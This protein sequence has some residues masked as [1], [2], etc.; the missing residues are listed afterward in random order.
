MSDSEDRAE[1]ADGVEG[2]SLLEHES[3]FTEADYIR[4]KNWPICRPIL[5]HN[6]ARDVDDLALRS[7]VRLA[8]A[9]W[10]VL[11]V[12]FIGNA[13]AVAAAFFSITASHWS[14]WIGLILSILYFCVC[15]PLAFVIYFLAYEG[16]RLRS[17][18]KMGSF[19]CLYPVQI[20]LCIWFALGIPKTG[21]GG[22][23]LIVHAWEDNELGTGVLNIISLVLWLVIGFGSAYVLTA[24]WRAFKQARLGGGQKVQTAATSIEHDDARDSFLD[25]D[26]EL[27]AAV[28]GKEV[29][30]SSSTT[31]TFASWG[32]PSKI[33][34]SLNLPKREAPE[35][36]AGTPAPV[37]T[38]SYDL[39]SNFLD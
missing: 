25:V 35:K 31:S 36:V 12:A 8:Y 20:I 21:G 11:L 14:N 39:P 9:L 17:A 13:L 24:M 19:F 22:L 5:Y 37:P 26:E 7:V 34:L 3:E 29:P 2:E 33:N 6:I 32:L 10:Y 16:A 23:V 27:A 4:K 1:G 30:P 18:V 28:Q 15:W 38:A